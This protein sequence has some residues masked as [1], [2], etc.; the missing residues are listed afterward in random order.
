MRAWLTSSARF[1][2][3]ASTL[4]MSGCLLIMPLEDLP[5]G[6]GG[7][8]SGGKGNTSG[9][10]GDTEAGDGAGGSSGGKSGSGTGG[11]GGKKPIDAPCETN[12]ECTERFAAQPARCRESDHQCVRLTTDICPLVY[13]H[14]ENPNAVFFGAFT[15]YDPAALEV[16]SIAWAHQLAIEEVNSDSSG[17]LPDGP[18]GKS[19]P[20]AMVL[21]SNLTEDVDEAMK[22]LIDD[23]QV[24]AVIATLRPGDLR[25]AFENR[26]EPLYLSPVPITRTLIDQDDDN[27]I[28]N[29]LGQPSDLA[30]LYA[31]LLAR[32][33]SYAYGDRG[34]PDDV[35]LRVAL[36]S[37]E[38]A[39]DSDLFNAV[40]PLLKF[41]GKTADENGINYRPFVIDPAEPKLGALS[42]TILD[43]RPHVIISTGSDLISSGGG[44]I[45]LVESAWDDAPG[46]DEDKAFRPQWLLSPFN[47]GNLEWLQSTIKENVSEVDSGMEKRFVGVSIASAADSSLQ[48]QYASHLRSKFPDAYVDSANYYDAIYY[49]AYGMY[50][51]G[52]D[53]PLSGDSIAR[54]L[55]RLTKGEP[56]N[57]GA[58]NKEAVLAELADP[59]KSVSLA[60]TLGPPGFDPKTGVRAA[61]GSVFCFQKSPVRV[62]LDVLRYDD[63]NDLL[64]GN[65]AASCFEGFEP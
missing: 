8:S 59:K 35:E 28:W 53:E 41:N 54:G 25:R 32:A 61:L 63:Q 10:A 17:G 9:S 22:H 44:L 16:N 39:F 2:A 7:K 58:L 45:E 64:T 48:N 24:P 12:A 20:L 60:S 50:A 34:L 23:V 56:F 33:E 1:I 62:K 30:P 29:L 19:R 36:V 49:L 18:G 3:V 4:G 11:S 51:A 52:T 13:G 57:V 40:Q 27:H 46:T 26:P 31:P 37:T 38:E 55:T 21:C 42:A 47:A 6:S 15:T 43:F 5:D 14:P 65:F